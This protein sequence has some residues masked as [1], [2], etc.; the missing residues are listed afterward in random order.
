MTTL[1]GDRP[2][3]GDDRVAELAQRLVR[4]RELD[5]AHPPASAPPAP[6]VEP[7]TCELG[8]AMASTSRSQMSPFQSSM[9][10]TG[11]SLREVPDLHG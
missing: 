4:G 10:A 2:G 6:P 9:R 5:R 8:L 7:A 1:R 11:T 3:L